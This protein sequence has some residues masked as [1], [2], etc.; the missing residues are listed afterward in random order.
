M[1]TKLINGFFW[2]IGFC[3][4][5]ALSLKLVGYVESLFKEDR[6]EI[7]KPITD[8][9]VLKVTHRV[10]PS[11]KGVNNLII[12]GDLKSPSFDKINS[13]S[14]MAELRNSDGGFVDSCMFDSAILE[15]VESVTFKIKCPDISN[16]SQFE[17]YH[18]ELQGLKW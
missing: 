14:L 16:E 4:A 10:V 8:F 9:T 3:L 11:E 15:P 5:A 6:F 18:F 13:F 17:N 12:T 1:K 2:G 7:A